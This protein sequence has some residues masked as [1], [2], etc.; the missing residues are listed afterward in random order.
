V[1]GQFAGKSN[2]EADGIELSDPAGA[3]PSAERAFYD[4][5]EL[6]DRRAEALRQQGFLTATVAPNLVS[7]RSTAHLAEWWDQHMALGEYTPTGGGYPQ[8]PDGW[9][10][11]KTS[12]NSLEGLRRTHRMAY[13]G[14][15]VAIR[16]PSVASIKS[17][18]AAQVPG[19]D[20][21]A[22]FDVPV[23][24]DFPGGEV[25]GWVRVLQT[26][27]GTWATKGMGFTVHQASYVAESVQCVLEA[28]HPTMALRQAGDLLERR[29]QRAARFGV[30]AEQVRSTWLTKMGFDPNTGTMIVTTGDGPDKERQYG[31]AVTEEVFRRVKT[32]PAPGKVFNRFIRGK[33]PRVEVVACGKCGRYSASPAGHRCPPTVSARQKWLPG[34]LLAQR[35]VFGG[36]DSPV[37]A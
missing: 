35:H 29:R 19:K 11:S 22:P 32:S 5:H 37:G 6:I 20:P 2:P 10:P 33:V 12:G 31:Y 7:P 24:A 28:R 4:L 21:G 23:T 30:A 27:D 25:S 17:F 13:V 16:M 15:Q 36:A 26:A 8:M 18:S 3:K 9:T 1:G 34:N 14:G